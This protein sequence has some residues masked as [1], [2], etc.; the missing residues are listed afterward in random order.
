YQPSQRESPHSVAR[1]RQRCPLARCPALSGADTK[2][3]RKSAPAVRPRHPPSSLPERGEI[4][5]GVLRRRGSV[6]AAAYPELRPSRERTRHPSIRRSRKVRLRLAAICAL[7]RRVSFAP[8]KI[9]RQLPWAEFCQSV[10]ASSTPVR[11]A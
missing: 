2:T 10:A 1:E 8:D 5:A 9:V 11:A 3:R 6:C 7:H 4:S